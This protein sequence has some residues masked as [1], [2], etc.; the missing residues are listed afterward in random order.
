MTRVLE[1]AGCGI[2]EVSD[3]KPL[4]ARMTGRSCI[5]DKLR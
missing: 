4:I 1:L 5:F 2:A 3:R